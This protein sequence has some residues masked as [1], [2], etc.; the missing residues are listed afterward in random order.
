MQ[1]IFTNLSKKMIF[2]SDYISKEKQI[3]MHDDVK[4]FEIFKLDYPDAAIAVI[5]KK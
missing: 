2:E 4:D 1:E 3:S 5:R